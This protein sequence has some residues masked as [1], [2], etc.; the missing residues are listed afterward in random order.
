[1]TPDTGELFADGLTQSAEAQTVQE[2]PSGRGDGVPKIISDRESNQRRS[3]EVGFLSFEH[4]CLLLRPRWSR[5]GRPQT[6][7]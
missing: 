5:P 4:F 2:N 3:G 7:I 1:M 6:S